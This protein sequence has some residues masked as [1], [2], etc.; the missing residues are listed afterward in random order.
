MK[1]ISVPRDLYML[2][3]AFIALI[4]ILK[5]VFIN[6]DIPTIARFTASF[7]WLL[8]LP[9]FPLTY[10]YKNLNFIERLSLSVVASAGLMGIGTYYLGLI[11]IHIRY[12]IL[13]LPVV[14]ICL[15]LL[16]LVLVKMRN[17][18]GSAAT[19]EAE[20]PAAAK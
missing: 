7:F 3:G 5:I 6:E 17:H 16:V 8:V 11:G 2:A 15:T 9:A 13:L 1:K 14:Y 10:I 20:A 4:I 18:G 12:S 19:K